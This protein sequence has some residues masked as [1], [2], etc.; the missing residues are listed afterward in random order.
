[1]YNLAIRKCTSPSL[2]APRLK[3]FEWKFTTPPGSNPGPAEPEADML[4]SEPTR[5]AL[6]LYSQQLERVREMLRKRY[7]TFVNQNLVLLQ[8]NNVIGTNSAWTTMLKIQRLGGMELLPHSAC[9]PDIAPSDYNRFGFTVH[10]L[11]GR[12][13]EN[14]EA[15]KWVSPN[16]SHQKPEIGSVAE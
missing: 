10:F 4:P 12:N 14:I 16:S 9:S 13:I 1:M 3:I 2:L 7:P 8:Q 11:R 5:R 15:S 6:D